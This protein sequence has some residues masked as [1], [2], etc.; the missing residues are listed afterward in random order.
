MIERAWL[1]VTGNAWHVF[2]TRV[3]GFPVVAVFARPKA[4]VT[5][6]GGWHWEL[7]IG[8]WRLPLRTREIVGLRPETDCGRT[9]PDLRLV[10]YRLPPQPTSVSVRSTPR[11]G[12]AGIVGISQS[13]S[14]PLMI[15]RARSE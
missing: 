12:S 8:D 11:P 13:V 15:L 2:T 10:L 1:I 5:E 9:T 14:V 4:D 7:E 3:P 6:P